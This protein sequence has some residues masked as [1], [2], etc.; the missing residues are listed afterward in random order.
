MSDGSVGAERYPD[1]QRMPSAY[2]GLK[3]VHDCADLPDCSA[4][5]SASSDTDEVRA[6]GSP[7]GMERDRDLAG[8]A[9][10]DGSEWLYTGTLASLG[11]RGLTG[12]GKSHLEEAALDVIRAE[13]GHLEH[14][15]FC[16]YDLG[17]LSR[18]YRAWVSS[19]PRVQPFYAVKCNPDIGILRTLAALGAGFDCASRS[20]LEAVLALGVSPSRMVF[21]NPVKFPRDLQLVQDLGIPVTFDSVNELRKVAT[22]SPNVRLILRIRSDDESASCMLGNKYGAEME[23]VPEL[24]STSVEL[25]LRI[26]GVSFHVG[27]GAKDP[28]A[29]KT[30]IRKARLVVDAAR[31][32]GFHISLLDIGG[33]MSC[34][35][36]AESGDISLCGFPPVITA[37]LEELFPADDNLTVIGEPGR[38]FAANA[39]SVVTQVFAKRH[40]SYIPSAPREYWISDG[41]YGSFNSILYDHAAPQGEPLFSPHLPEIESQDLHRSCVWGPT[42]DGLDVVEKE[43][44]LPELREGDWLIYHNSG[45]YTVCASSDF[46]GFSVSRPHAVYVY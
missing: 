22:C 35:V 14:P 40:R 39:A 1:T 7:S 6:E 33:G 21:A 46:N 20:E 12:R 3:S 44:Y 25:G 28:M 17:M 37:T 38:F 19:M 26:M 34:N 41:L 36:D 29:Y 23:E 24:L 30:A 9:S 5:S 10:L 13:A 27:S 11:A 2:Q 32:L 43:A 15:L 18:T 16:I 42:C 8:S 31:H 45:A 4:G